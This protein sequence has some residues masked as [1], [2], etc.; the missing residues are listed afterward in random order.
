MS[1]TTAILVAKRSWLLEDKQELKL[2]N[3]TKVKAPGEI[4]KKT[5]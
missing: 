5:V 3:E 4:K 2:N 1:L